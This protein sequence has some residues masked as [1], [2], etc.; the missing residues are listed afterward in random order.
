M[1][2]CAVVKTLT[3]VIHHQFLPD[4]GGLFSPAL[5]GSLSLLALPIVRK[6]WR[7]YLCVLNPASALEPPGELHKQQDAWS[8]AF[9]SGVHPGLTSRDRMSIETLLTSEIPGPN[10]N[11]Q[12]C[13]RT[14]GL[15]NPEQLGRSFP[16]PEFSCLWFRVLWNIFPVSFPSKVSTALSR[17]YKVWASG[18]NKL[19]HNF[20]Q[21]WNWRYSH[22]RSQ[23][24][25]TFQHLGVEEEGQAKA[26][27]KAGSSSLQVHLLTHWLSFTRC[28]S[29]CRSLHGIPDLE[30]P[31][32]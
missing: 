9:S 10:D 13:R 16:S 28:V 30:L 3:R 12:T 8:W 18:N 4:D 22:L 2:F 15:A 19:E 26:S 31:C 5:L 23:V 14:R 11:C 1:K 17:K 24:G 6:F 32:L 21:V 25:V 29:R 20:L 7:T 27:A